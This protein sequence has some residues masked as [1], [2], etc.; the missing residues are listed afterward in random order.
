MSMNANKYTLDSAIARGAVG[1]N[2]G[3]VKEYPYDE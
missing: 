3:Y 2:V 1:Y